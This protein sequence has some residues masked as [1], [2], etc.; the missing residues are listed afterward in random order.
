MKKVISMLLVLTVI[1]A[2]MAFASVSVNAANTADS[3]VAIAEGELGNTN[4]RKYSSYS[5]AWCA[6]FVSW[7]ARQ[8]GVDSIPSTASCYSMYNSMIANGCQEVASPQKGDIVFFFCNSCTGT[9]NIW[10]HVGIMINSSTSIDGNYSGKVSYDNSYS[11]YGSLG[12]KHSNGISKIY[13]RPLYGNPN[14]FPGEED[15]SWNVPAEKTANTYLNTYN[16]AGVMESGHNI[17]AGDPCYIERV[18]KNGYAWVRY[19]TP[20]GDRWAYA[21]ASGFSLEKKGYN[22]VGYCDSVTSNNSGEIYLRGWAFDWDNVNA[23]LLIHVYVNDKHYATLIADQPRS[24]VNDI[25]SGAGTNHGFE[26]TLIVNKSGNLNIKVYAINVGSGSNALVENGERTVSVSANSTTPKQIKTCTLDGHEYRLY[27]CSTTWE[28]AKTICEEKGGYLATITS[29]REQHM[30]YDFLAEYS[31]SD[32]F[33]GAKKTNGVWKWVT[34]EPFSYTAWAENQPDFAGNAEFYLGAQK[35]N[36]TNNN[37]KFWNDFTNDFSGISGF[38]FESGDIEENKVTPSENPPS[39]V[40]SGFVGNS[41]TESSINGE[42]IG[43][44]NQ[45]RFKAIRAGLE[46]CSGGIKYAAHFSKTGWSDYVQ[47]NEICGSESNDMSS[48][49][50]IKMELYGDVASNYNLFYCAYVRDKGWLGWAKNGEAAGS[51]GGALPITAIRIMLIPQI[52]YSAHVQDKGWMNRVKDKEICGT[53]GEELRIESIKIY[54]KDTAYGNIRYK[55]HVAD[56]NWGNS[57]YNGKQSGTT[58]L[59]LQ[60]EAF[61]VRLDGKAEEMFDVMYQAHVQD[62][63]WMAWVRNGETAGTTG[64]VLRLEA[65]RIMIVPKGY[66]GADSYKEYTTEVFTVTFDPMG[67]DCSLKTKAVSYCSFFQDLPKPTKSNYT[68]SGWYDS[69]SFTNL[70]TSSSTLETK[71]DITLYAKW[72]QK[73][74]GDADGDEEIEIIDVTYIMRYGASVKI[75]IPKEILMNGDVNRDGELDIVDATLIQRYL[76]HIPTKYKIGELAE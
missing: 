38:I 70:V 73:L 20:S 43:I 47:D 33:L 74:L 41:W 60:T 7:C 62:K 29:D 63:D 56:L 31:P 3:L 28:N 57:V 30:L 24:D 5:N 6:D 40:Y 42:V 52:R 51:T 11:H 21:L 64:Q 8:A 26:T 18:Y 35:H 59:K 58:D 10:C 48:I 68:F 65:F 46:N 12:Y 55:T 19:P 14:N 25:Y 50:A 1:F 16:S 53:T 15:T 75:S 27:A 69:K 34:E 61:Q 71:S 39:V 54:L 9:A 44:E 32:F 66:T 13:V 72:I 37:L 17:D 49:E 76:I 67:G 45:N 36:R 4:Y 2:S 23:E 22:P